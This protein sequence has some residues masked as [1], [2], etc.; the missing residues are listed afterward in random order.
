MRLT[1]AEDRCKDPALPVAHRAAVG[2]G[3]AEKDVSAAAPLCRI[4]AVFVAALPLPRHHAQVIVTIH[5]QQEDTLLNSSRGLYLVVYISHLKFHS[6]PNKHTAV[7]HMAI[8]LKMPPVTTS[9]LLRNWCHSEPKCKRTDY[10]TSRQYLQFWF[11]T[12]AQ[13][14]L[15]M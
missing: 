7:L 3:P 5:L 8:F 12:I 11:L 9:N 1:C 10:C 6:I 4:D 15:L 14:T 13:M 2:W